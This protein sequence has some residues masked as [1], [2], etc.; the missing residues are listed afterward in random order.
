[1]GWKE[2]LRHNVFEANMELVRRDLVIYTFGN[3]SGIDR[4]HGIIAIKPSGVPY[5]VLTED[6]IVL[7]DLENGAAEGDYRPS[8]DTKTHLELYRSFPEIGGVAH[9]HSPFATSWA[10]AKLP[11]PCYG[12]T[13]ADFVNGDIPCTALLTDDEI[14]GD[15]EAA[16]GQKIVAA[17]K[18][19]PHEHTP[20]VLVASHGPFTW[21]E[22]PQQAVSNSVILEYLAQMALQTQAL[23]PQIH[24]IQAALLSKHFSRKHGTTAYYGQQE[25][26]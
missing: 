1:M 16:T 9:T 23:N 13:H 12:T 6:A 19:L 10:Q 15:Y 21:G 20:M 26:K 18:N 3:V 11:I 8:S 17:F 24:P 25:L 14:N 4:N 5:E 7:V 22:T 2:K